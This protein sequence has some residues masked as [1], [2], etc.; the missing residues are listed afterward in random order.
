MGKE[1]LKKIAQ[2]LSPLLT[3]GTPTDIFK[4][5]LT[6]WNKQKEYFN[7]RFDMTDILKLVIYII[8]IKNFR[9]VDD[10]DV[11]LSNL[12]F[13]G[14]IKNED[15][16]EQFTCNRCSG[17]GYEECDSCN[18][19]GKQ[20][21]EQ[22]DG[23]GELTCDYCNGSGKIEED[24]GETY[25]CDECGGSGKIDCN[26][27]DGKEECEYCSGDGQ[28]TCVDCN[29]NGEM[30]SDNDMFENIVIVSWNRNLFN[31]CE[32][33]ED[34]DEPTIS[35]DNF[36]DINDSYILIYSNSEAAEMSESLDSDKLY[37]YH[38]DD[39]PKLI[40]RSNRFWPTGFNPESSS[41]FT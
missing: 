39:S 32:L 19:T 3:D 28:D 27:E 10:G 24:D 25:E 41:Y 9:N 14:F 12:F 36:Q 22:C 35:Y 17:D 40:Y 20:E 18:G 23:E 16:K 34:T 8:A 7:Q 33:N 6:L 38:M 15:E 21:C 2:N 26:C 13:A 1:R 30:E 31:L 37:C 29:G 4:S 11:I 5:F